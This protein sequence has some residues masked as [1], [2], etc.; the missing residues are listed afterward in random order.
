VVASTWRG[1]RSAWHIEVERLAKRGRRPWTW[2]NA[3]LRGQLLSLALIAGAFALGGWRAAAFFLASALWGKALLEIVN[4]ME[5]YGLVREPG[6][7]VKPRHSWN[8]TR[9]LSSWTLFNLTRH[10]HHHAQGE[11]PFQDLRPLPDAPAMVAGYL[12]TIVFTLIPPLWHR[13]MTP[14]LLAWDRDQANDA[15]RRLAAA[16]SLRSGLP[17]LVRAAGG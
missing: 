3:V 13:L 10:S 14:R 8:T 4:Y 12:T 16:A 5:H 2:R 6:A 11:V 17:A 9:R 1:N 15:E 7:P